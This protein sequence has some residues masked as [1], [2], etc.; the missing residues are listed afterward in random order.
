MES[1]AMA[2]EEIKY[3]NAEMAKFEE[4]DSDDDLF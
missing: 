4:P 2:K 3:V 1:I